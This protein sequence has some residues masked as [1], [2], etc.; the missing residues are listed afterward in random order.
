MIIAA[1]NVFFAIEMSFLKS[2]LTGRGWK[3]IK[4]TDIKFEL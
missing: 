4:L 1:Q 3:F 2:E